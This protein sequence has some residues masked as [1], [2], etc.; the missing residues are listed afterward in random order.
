MSSNDVLYMRRPAAW[1]KD[2]ARDGLPLGNGR[3]GAL[4]QGGAGIEEILFNRYDVWNGSKYSELPDITDGLQ[5]M[6]DFIEQ[7]DYVSANDI[8]WHE[9][10]DK[11]YESEVGW[12]MILGSMK[13]HMKT[14]EAFSH[15][16]RNLYMDKAEC[17]VSYTQAS[18]HV[19]RRSFIS[20]KDDT[21][22][23]EY[24]ANEDT[25][26]K[27]SFGIFDDGTAK[28]S[29]VCSEVLPNLHKVCR[30]NGID[31]VVKTAQ[32]AYSV[33]V[34]VF[35]ADVTVEGD[36]L[37]LC[38]KSF[39]I[40]VKCRSGRGSQKNLKAPVDFDYDQKLKEHLP[41]HRR[42]YHSADI[43]LGR[44]R[45]QT[46]E[47]L[48][49]EVYEN[50]ASPELVE[51]MWRFGRYLF[52]CGT[53]EGGLP[54]PLY[55]LWHTKYDA[56]W[57]QNV[58]NENVEIIY[59]HAAVGGLIRL[60]RPLID[61]YY[62]A[63]DL[64][65]E[66]AKKL[67]G[68]RG[69]FIGGYTTPANR[70]LCAIVPVILNF[71]GVA[72]WL[73]Q[74]FFQY[75]RM[76]G[77]RRM[78]DE[79]I[80]PFMIEAAQF[81]LDYFRYDENGKI[82]YYPSISPENTPINLVK[83]VVNV[84][85]R[86]H[87]NPVTKNSVMEIAIVKELF[88]NLITLIQETDQ[89][90]EYLPQLQKALGDLPEYM[91]NEDG[92]LKEWIAPELEDNYFHRHL[93]HIYPLFPGDEVVKDEQPEL[94][95]A[96]ERAVDLRQL[97]AQCGWSVVHMASIYATM[98]R[99]ES[100]MKCLDTMLK[101]YMINNFFSNCS[102]YRNMGLS[103]MFED[104]V[105]QVDANMGFVNAV[106]KMIFDERRNYLLLLPAI[107]ER[108][109][110]G[111]ASNLCFSGGKVSLKWDLKAHKL[112]AKIVFEREGSVQVRLPEGFSSEACGERIY[113]K[114]GT[115]VEINCD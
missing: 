28:Y 66:N 60:V 18:R 50:Q 72:G 87:R 25:E 102:D 56:M 81:Y 88:T 79:K 103:A 86:V 59:W 49:D 80:L 39:R 74:H 13:I 33:Q 48:L 84:Q 42:L 12:P 51:K 44:G 113:G 109:S 37:N 107:S 95:A 54:V 4:V 96:L 104:V 78:L 47:A 68:C 2:M 114:K 101:G 23:F 5:K 105:V 94:Y 65:R 99:G 100:V 71:T 9:L 17:E 36:A 77:D 8:M 24:Q 43:R 11:G 19:C 64:F 1:P 6:R 73:S 26:V 93:S 21:F 89:Y 58:A 76:S 10:Q 112:Q 46:N 106:Q 20:R 31:F 90:T 41:R 35:G 62:D 27:I 115:V 111:S 92:A 85:G 52:V 16:R 15:Y 55:G 34:R 63:M 67:F 7:G 45:K 30:E 108:L 29:Q 97:G 3:T 32:M 70:H 75:Y 91:I 22:Y 69:I 53:C 57:N 83:A 14:E 40:A 110:I 82:V 38:A 61:Y 98:G